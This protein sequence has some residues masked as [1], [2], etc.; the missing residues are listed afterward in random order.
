MSMEKNPRLSADN[1]LW[2]WCEALTAFRGI[3]FR[4]SDHTYRFEDGTLGTSATTWLK[5]YVKPFDAAYGSVKKAPEMGMTPEQVREKWDEKARA[6][7]EKGTA[8][9]LWLEQ[10]ILGNEA[11]DPRPRLKAHA[12]A[13]LE[14][15]WELYVP[16]RPEWVIGDREWGICGQVDLVAMNRETGLLHIFDWKTNDELKTR[17]DYYHTGAFSDVPDSK[18]HHYSLQLSLYRAILERNTRLK[19]GGSFL[20]WMSELEQDFHVRPCEEYVDKVNKVLTSR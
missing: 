20:V 11:P 18:Y 5:Q 16:M 6:S 13:A 17:S 19:F 2:N 10:R 15:L 9:H 4:E 3:V 14:A 12:E 7:S 1:T 8:T